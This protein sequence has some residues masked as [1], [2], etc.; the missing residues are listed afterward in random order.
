M[1]LTVPEVTMTAPDIVR[2]EVLG[3][4][5]ERGY[6]ETLAS[7]DTGPSTFAITG[8]ADN[9]AGLI[10]IECSAATFSS[11]N[12]GL[13]SV[14]AGVLGCTEAN[15]AWI[16]TYVDATHLDLNQSVFVNAYTSGGRLSVPSS[17]RSGTDPA[18]GLSSYYV[19]VGYENKHKRWQDQQCTEFLDEVAAVD[20][21]NYG[22][23]GGLTVTKATLKKQPYQTGST[24]GTNGSFV[25]TVSFRYFIYLKLSGNLGAGD[26]TIDFP[27]DTGLSDKEFTFDDYE[28]RCSSIHVNHIGH[29]PDDA[30]KM[31]YLSQWAPGQAT[32]GAIEFVTAY[33]LSAFSIIN[34]AGKEVYTGSITLRTAPT[35][36][37]E[38]QPASV[39]KLANST[40]TPLVITGITNATPGV[41]TYTGTDP[42]NGDYI[43]FNHIRGMTGLNNVFGRV[44]NVNAGANTFEITNEAG[45]NLNTSG[46]GTYSSGGLVYFTQAVNPAATYVYG[47]DFSDFAPSHHA[48]YRIRIAGLGVSDEFLIDP[49]VWYLSTAVWGIGLYHQRNGIA[50]DGRFGY[51]IPLAYK[52][53]VDRIVYKSYCPCFWNTEGAPSIPADAI[54]ATNAANATWRAPGTITN[55]WGGHRDA[56]DED[57]FLI[58]HAPSFSEMLEIYEML[59]ENVRDVSWGIPKS[60]ES[61]DPTLYAGTDDLGDLVHE[62]VWYFDFYRQMQ[63]PDGSIPSGLFFSGH[64]SFEPVYLNRYATYVSLP[65]HIGNFSFVP[66]ACQLARIFGAAGFPTLAATWEAAAIAAYDWAEN[67]YTDGTARDDYYADFVTR[68]GWDGTKYN[69]NMALVQTQAGVRRNA[70]AT[71]LY[72]L[73]GDTQYD[74]VILDPT[75]GYTSW[76]SIGSENGQAAW[77]YINSSGADAGVVTSLK[78]TMVSRGASVL[79][80]TEGDSSYRVLKFGNSNWEFG[81]GGSSLSACVNNMMRCHQFTGDVKYL[82]ALQAGLSYIL[83]ANQLGMCYT[84][85]HGHR[86]PTQFL[87]IDRMTAGIDAPKGISFYGPC[88][89][90]ITMSLNFSDNPQHDLTEAA[91]GSIYSSDYK[92]KHELVPSRGGWPLYETAWESPRLIEI[93][94][95]SFGQVM[96]AYV[97]AALYLQAYDGNTATEIFGG[98]TRFRITTS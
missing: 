15:G 3:P 82:K 83:G 52:P 33:G 57:S 6:V 47:L 46:L 56:G 72:R 39:P 43:Y 84:M 9:G 41:V 17:W 21:A 48:Y 71:A 1:A 54:S 30:D 73:T 44:A 81:A 64:G 68:A 77:D 14:V 50:L 12:T 55:A 98:R 34:A 49:A 23:I 36:T 58:G 16:M 29:R 61:R 60:S 26:H 85:K 28:T 8:C 7:I 25:G 78:A 35:D 24:R 22:T 94:E 93:M 37:E 45:T 42:S 63:N 74:D 32:N 70:A 75:T 91:Q 40:V 4:A 76:T 66:G 80:A 92:D 11:G 59:P 10:R 95:Y 5:I 79:G 31:A 96:A 51:T 65:D 38:Y 67:I 90:N 62:A 19:Q 53:G 69:T 27:T 20:H 86:Y 88:A 2:V 13:N 89:P 87:H 18:S 97:R